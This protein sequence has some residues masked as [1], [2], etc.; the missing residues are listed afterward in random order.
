[1]CVFIIFLVVRAEHIKELTHAKRDVKTTKR[2]VEDFTSLKTI[3]SQL[4]DV[5]NLR[6]FWEYCIQFGGPNCDPFA[7]DPDPIIVAYWMM[8]KAIENG[9]SNSRRNWMSGVTSW[10]KI[11]FHDQTFFKHKFFQNIWK[12][13]ET[14]YN[15][16]HV[17]PPKAPVLLKMIV[18]YLKLI[19]CVPENYGDY[20]VHIL[21]VGFYILINYF[22][23]SRPFELTITDQTVDEE[24]QIIMTGLRWGDIK[25]VRHSEYTKNYL[26]L[27]INWFKNQKDRSEPKI[28]W[29]STPVCG[30]KKCICIYCDI[31]KLW[32][33]YKTACIRYYKV[34]QDKARIQM[35]KYGKLSSLLRKQIKNCAVTAKNYVFVGKNGAIWRPEKLNELIKDLA[36]KLNLKN[37]ERYRGYSVKVG[38]VSLCRQ[39]NLDMLKVMRYVQWSVNN[40]PHVV[41][42]YISYEREE[43]Q[44]IPFEMIHGRNIPGGHCKN[45]RN[46]KYLPIKQIWSEDIEQVLCQ[47]FV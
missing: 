42:R 41:A 28:I 23:I 46:D 32:R 15:K 9:N 43:L 14:R 31:I 1:M 12:L 33:V 35:D 13:L 20:N 26:E 19:G 2:L 37:P 10:G 47:R 40:L 34:I 18:D 4:N 45:L 29:M 39:Q 3:G 17:N 44:I 22:S 6:S 11:H 5:S 21:R 30:N 24:I 8:N 36:N 7:L 38:A 25:L 16:N 27:T